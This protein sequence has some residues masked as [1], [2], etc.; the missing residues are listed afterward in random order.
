VLVEWTG[1]GYGASVGTAVT[2]DAVE[3]RGT[4]VK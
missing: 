3:V 2:L 1:T 4:L